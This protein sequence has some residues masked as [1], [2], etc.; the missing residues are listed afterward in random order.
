[1]L[2]RLTVS[3]SLLTIFGCQSKTNTPIIEAT[4]TSLVSNVK[5][6][7]KA[8]ETT[9]EEEIAKWKTELFLNGEVGP[10]CIEDYEKW[11][12]QNPQYYWG[13]QEINILKHDFNSDNSE[14]A[15]V[16]FEA[17]NCVG[18]NGTGSDFAMLLY[19]YNNQ[20]L[21]NKNITDKITVELL[22]ELTKNGI[23]NLSDI[24]INYKSLSN[25]INGSYRVWLSDDAHCCPGYEGTFNYNPNDFSIILK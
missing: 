22:E 14:D 23:T 5:A 11:A 8:P 7:S 1:M 17:E 21:S 10:P 15:L 16:Y 4:N 19:S 25:T 3:I 12:E 24:V 6:I 9:I 18:G 20:I 2:Y 13:M